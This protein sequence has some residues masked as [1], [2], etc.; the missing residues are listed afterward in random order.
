MLADAESEHRFS[1]VFEATVWWKNP[2]AL[3]LGFRPSSR[4]GSGTYTIQKCLVL[5][6]NCMVTA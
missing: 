2:T 1:I 5:R 4:I 6:P 3:Q